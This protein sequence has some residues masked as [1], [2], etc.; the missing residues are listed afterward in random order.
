M[1]KKLISLIIIIAVAAGLSGCLGVESVDQY[2]LVPD[3]TGGKD[4]EPAPAADNVFSL[5]YN[6]KYSLNPLTATNH[7]NQLVCNLVYENLVEVDNDF[8]VIPNVITEWSCSEDGKIW[9]FK[10]DTTHVFHDG[11]NVTGRDVDYTIQ[12]TIFSDRFSGRF[13]SFQGTSYTDDTVLLYLGIADTQIIKLMNLPLIKY[14]TFTDNR[15]EHPVGSGPYTFSED[16]TKLEAY[17]GYPGYEDLP[18]DTVYLVNY[19]TADETIDAF[20]DSIIDVVMND[21]S[22]LANLGYADINETHTF[23]TTNLHYVVINQDS[24]V[25]KYSAFRYAMNYA[26]DREN[27]VTLL[28]GN[29]VASAVPMYPTCDIYPSEFAD[30]IGYDLE[31]CK[32]VLENGGILDYDDDGKLELSQGA[33]DLT[34]TFL[35]CSDSSAKAGVVRKFASDMESIGITVETSS[36]TWDEYL[37]ALE[38]GEFDLYYG[39]IKLRADFDITELYDIRTKDNEDYNI[40][41]SGGK[42]QNALSYINAYLSSSDYDRATRYEEMCRYISDN[43]SLISIGFEKQQLITH[44]GIVRGV[45][46][47][48]G[49]PMYDFINWQINLDY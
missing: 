23:A 20:E 3:S 44:R 45:N 35:L 8:N 48:I 9:T 38:E 6:P 37:E 34:V 14:G 46:P 32:R 42:D 12:K 24:D 19:T 36:V 13:A 30:S 22:S 25:G 10:I 11:T 5:N 18:V 29:A 49:N 7:S 15:E 39:E 2:S 16:M 4:V 21:P 47:N 33:K 28:N 26:F 43:G 40:N 27:L 31:M 17:E 1:L 41:Y